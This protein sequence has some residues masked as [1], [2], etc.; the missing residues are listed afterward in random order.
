M[1][2][3]VFLFCLSAY[4]LYSC[5]PEKERTRQEESSSPVFFDLKKLVAEDIGQLERRSCTAFKVGQVNDRQADGSVDSIHWK[6]ELEAVAMADINKSSWIALIETD[7][8]LSEKGMTISYRSNNSKIPIRQMNIDFN[9]DG[10]VK[11]VFIERISKNLIFE[12][13][14][15][16]TYRP[17]KSIHATGSQGALFMKAQTFS[18]NTEFICPNE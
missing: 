17:G 12:S 9:A 11:E 1:K 10:N 5:T 3:V 18:I 6:R 8:I 15:S 13:K 4:S 7:T 16:I 14:Q 2:K